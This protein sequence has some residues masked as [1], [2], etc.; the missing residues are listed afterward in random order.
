MKDEKEIEFEFK[1]KT[2]EKVKFLKLINN[3]KGNICRSYPKF[4]LT[5]LGLSSEE[6]NRVAAFRTSNRLPILSYIYK[7][8]E[9]NFV[10]MWRSSQNKVTNNN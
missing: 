8:N 10:T 3:E 4:F 6:V 7:A 2:N 1:H 9:N 5:P